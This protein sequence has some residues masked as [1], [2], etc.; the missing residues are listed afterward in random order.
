MYTAQEFFY[1]R[2]YAMAFRPIDATASRLFLKRII[3]FVLGRLAS[4][5]AE[6]VNSAENEQICRYSNG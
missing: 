6:N 2:N 4:V 5:D 3:V 1:S